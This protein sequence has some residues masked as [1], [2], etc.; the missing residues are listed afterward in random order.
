MKRVL[1]LK[2]GKPFVVKGKATVRVVRKPRRSKEDLGAHALE[3][4]SRLKTA[5]PDAHCELDHETPLQLLIATILSAQCTDKRVNMVTPLVFRTFPTA[6]SLADADPA[7]LEEMIKSTGFF[8]NKTKSPIAL[9]KA[10]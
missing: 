10:L 8:R 3:V 1:K 9:G 4:F 6:Q 5:H 2:K 7:Q